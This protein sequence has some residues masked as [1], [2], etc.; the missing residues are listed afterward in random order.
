MVQKS[1]LIIGNFN[2]EMEHNMGFGDGEIMSNNIIKKENA[3][4]SNGKLLI[5][6]VAEEYNGYDYTSAR[7]RTKT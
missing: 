6:A 1:T 5:K 4:V 2:L 3:R 7:I